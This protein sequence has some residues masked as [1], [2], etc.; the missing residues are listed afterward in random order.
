MGSSSEPAR[1]VTREK[2]SLL[3]SKS[4]TLARTC[5]RYNGRIR[6]EIRPSIITQGEEWT[7]GWLAPR[8]RRS[9]SH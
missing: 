6:E 2:L 3:I 5:S 7:S 9:C 1:P 8:T 4:Q